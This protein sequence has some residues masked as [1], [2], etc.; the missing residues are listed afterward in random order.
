METGVAVI[1]WIILLLTSTSELK[2]E[3]TASSPALTPGLTLNEVISV[4]L[5]VTPKSNVMETQPDSTHVS[6]FP[7]HNETSH[8]AATAFSP[9][10]DP[11]THT[12]VMAVSSPSPASTQTPAPG[13]ST[14]TTQD[15]SP[16]LTSLRSTTITPGS[17]MTLTA[18]TAASTSL[19]EEHQTSHQ[20]TFSSSE[21][22][23]TASSV[24]S[25]SPAS[26][27]TALTDKTQPTGPVPVENPHQDGASELDVGDED[28]DSVKVPHASPWDPLFAA[29]VSI[30]IVSTALVSVMLFL[31]F[32]Q[33]SEHPEFHRLQD[34]PM[35]DLL[36]DTPLSR[37]SY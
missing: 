29:L 22:I 26:T 24:P 35:D 36:E 31:R 10:T 21:T 1:M 23:Q 18:S 13:R 27:W 17:M 11:S 5:H 8:A 19:S 16:A 37:Y 32:R 33:Q 25:S 14:E 4:A 2:G 30:F 6:E 9:P 15:T 28:S 12:A 3:S 20:S 34:L 7:P